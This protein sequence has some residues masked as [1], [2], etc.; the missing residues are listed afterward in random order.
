MVG[1]QAASLPGQPSVSATDLAATDTTA[2]SL[3]LFPALPLLH[4]DSWQACHVD[5]VCLGMPM[6]QD[7]PKM[8]AMWIDQHLDKCPPGIVVMP[9][10]CVS[11][12]GIHGMQLIKWR[13]LQ[14]AVAER[15]QTQYVFLATQLFAS[16]SAY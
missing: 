14:P 5:E 9:D 8:W 2:P 13:N 4:D 16:P 11:M 1:N 10:S 6:L 15:Q 3:P 12:C 7:S